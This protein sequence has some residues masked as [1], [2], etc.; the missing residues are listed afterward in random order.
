MVRN[1]SFFMIKYAPTRIIPSVITK[2]EAYKNWEPFV[3]MTR[4]GDERAANLA[5]LYTSLQRNFSMRS[6][7]YKVEP[8]KK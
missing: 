4:N 8:L 5:N 6:R 7:R 1:E 2:S 3:A